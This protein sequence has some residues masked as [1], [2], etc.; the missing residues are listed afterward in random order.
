VT[1]LCLVALPARAHF[2]LV[3][4]ASWASQD[5]FGGPQKSAPCGQDDPGVPA[6]PTG[7]VTTVQQGST[8]TITIDEKIFHPGHYRVS[9]AA[10]QASLPAD[11]LVTAGSTPCGSTDIVTSPALPLLAD[12]LLVH[13]T[14]FPRQ[15]TVQ[16]QLPAGFT[17]AN[18]TLQVTEFMS[19]HGLNVPGGC[20][21][22]HCANLTIA[23]DA[24]AGTPPPTTP[25]GC[26][27]TQPGASLLASG[28]VALLVRRRLT[29]TRR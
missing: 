18:C 3:A 14:P 28:V 21:Y 15:Q 6:T 7:A 26:G 19:N 23:A 1:F 9:L 20:F 16:V 22:H 12:G 11:P 25:Q 5:A 27:C 17:C 29:A 13:D 24:D 4:P 8:L 10:D 2:T